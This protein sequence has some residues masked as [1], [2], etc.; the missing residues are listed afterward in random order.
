[1]NYW[2]TFD[3]NLWVTFYMEV[4]DLKAIKSSV[5]ADSSLDEKI[6]AFLYMSNVNKN[7]YYLNEFGKHIRDTFFKPREII[8][9]N[10]NVSIS[11]KYY[12]PES[13][14]PYNRNK[15]TPSEKNYIITTVPLK[16]YLMKLIPLL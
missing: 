9:T 4:P 16:D 10:F 2:N 11:P 12:P 5:T 14:S 7:E 8:I 6:D 15:N 1:M 13:M 3:E